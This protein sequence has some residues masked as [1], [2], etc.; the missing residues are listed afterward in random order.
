[1]RVVAISRILDE[2]DIIEAFIRHTAAY[3]RS[4]IILDNGS[5]DGTIDIIRSLK[6]EGFNIS[7]Y[8]NKAV[9]FS[10]QSFMN[11]MYN[12]AVE[13]HGADWV[14]C[15][16]ADEFIDDRHVPGGLSGM[17]SS[18]R[19][20][21]R[22]VK[23]PWHQYRYT[24]SDNFNE[25]IVPLRMTY[26]LPDPDFHKV[27]VRGNLVGEDVS[28]GNGGHDI[29]LDGEV[30]SNS[31]LLSEIFLAHYSERNAAQ[32]IVKFVRGWA[33]AKAADRGMR[34]QNISVHYRGPFETLRDRPQEILRD[35]RFMKYK[36]EQSDLTADPIQYRGK[37]LRYTT[38]IDFEMLAVRSLVGYLEALADR[39]AALVDEVPAAKAYV[40]QSNRQHT[41]LI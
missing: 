19:T 8:Q 36:G 23:I 33:K 12:E 4:H 14:A 16:D 10:E 39:H 27:F 17:L 40:E 28:I 35:E 20:D 11:F 6:A 24:R 34:L 31:P 37:P 18:V 9:S 30:P 5:T 22:A 1:M 41:K 13:E 21:V 25:I 7:V 15:L 32:T 29:Y 2:A 38:K 26:R 3:A